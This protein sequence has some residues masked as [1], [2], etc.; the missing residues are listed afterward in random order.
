MNKRVFIIVAILL[1][2]LSFNVKAQTE[3]VLWTNQNLHE[4]IKVY[5]KG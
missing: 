4:Y 3:V 2:A 1:S 5:H